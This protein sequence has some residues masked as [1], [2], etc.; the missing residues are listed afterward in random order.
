[1]R[2]GKKC[3]HRNK[4][5][6]RRINST[7][8]KKY[9]NL[10]IQKCIIHM[11]IEFIPSYW[12]ECK[13]VYYACKALFFKLIFILQYFKNKFKWKFALG[14]LNYPYYPIYVYHLLLNEHHEL[15]YCTSIVYSY[16]GVI[17]FHLCFKLA[18]QAFCCTRCK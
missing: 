4:K 9:L 1:M 14:I 17:L 15:I 7:K 13:K 10:E 5:N 12:K 6:L 2:E 18:L 8:D 16:C 3:I 11:Q